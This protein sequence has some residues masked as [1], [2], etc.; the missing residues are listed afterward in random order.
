MPSI[1]IRDGRDGNRMAKVFESSFS[2]EQM[3]IAVTAAV[4]ASEG[5]HDVDLTINHDHIEVF[6]NADSV[7]E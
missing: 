1:K 6:V 5:G 3:L 4:E 7:T 2:K